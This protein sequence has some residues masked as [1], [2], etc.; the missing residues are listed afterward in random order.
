MR[1][2]ERL[3]G[4]FIIFILLTF[5]AY[6]NSMNV[7]GRIGQT[8][9]QITEVEQSS[10]KQ[11]SENLT[12]TNDKQNIKN[13]NQNQIKDQLDIRENQKNLASKQDSSSETINNN[14]NSKR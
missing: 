9:Q 4:F 5:S 12:Q 14:L 10:N 3:T 1:R 6:S 7:G 13:L 8:N 11:D 2:R